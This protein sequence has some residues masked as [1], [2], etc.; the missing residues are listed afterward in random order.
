MLKGIIHAHSTYSDGEY[1][2]KELREVFLSGGSSFVCMSDHAEYF[3]DDQLRQY[4]AECEELSDEKFLFIPGL[5]FTCER[6][7]HVLGYGVTRRI[8]SED[9]Q[10]VIG[11][12]KSSDNGVSVIAH[13]MDSAFPWIE[14]FQELPC[15]IETWNSKYDGRYAP[16]PGTFHLLD[17]MQQ[18]SPSMHAY[19]GVDFHWKK[20]FR[21]LYTMVEANS[22]DRAEILQSLKKGLYS[23]TKDDLELPADGR[24]SESLLAHFASR[25]ARSMRF[26]KFT[27]T[28]KKVAD[29]FGA[30]LPEPVKGQLRRIF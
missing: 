21:Q 22:L 25:N 5:E 7:M 2:L 11:H 10:R 17:R 29:R 23:G 14:T 24:V 13:P 3:D 20:Q 19:Y 26:R 6:R 9:P 16:R 8:D 18:R 28:V 4:A 12:I 15:G 27:K 30:R 1:T